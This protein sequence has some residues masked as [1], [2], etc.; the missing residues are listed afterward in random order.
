MPKDILLTAR[1]VP[2]RAFALMVSKDVAKRFLDSTDRRITAREML[3][4]LFSNSAISNDLGVS[5]RNSLPPPDEDPDDDAR[6]VF[7]FGSIIVKS[8]HL[9]STLPMRQY[10]LSDENELAATKV[11]RGA[12]NRMGIEV[13]EIL[14][15]GKVNGRDTLIQ[16]R[17]SGVTLNVAWPYLS[18][19]QK[20][21]FKS[22]ARKVLGQFRNIYPNSSSSL[23]S[24]LVPDN[25]PVKHR[26][27]TEEEKSILFGKYRDHAFD[28][29]AIRG[30]ERSE[31]FA[32][33]TTILELQ[34]SL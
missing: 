21:S 2:A 9:K 4:G 14:F 13:P 5:F 26:N 15:A 6:D 8:S 29:K 24:Y 27:I 17:I 33:C 1:P 28:G 16:T 34:I 22:R 23:P 32:L 31:D 12:F 18:A 30:E 19:P 25:D 3:E 20:V 7:A 11:V 10:S